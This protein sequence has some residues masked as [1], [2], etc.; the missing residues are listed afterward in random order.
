MFPTTAKVA[1]L[2][3]RPGETCLY[4]LVLDN[5]VWTKFLPDAK[6]PGYSTPWQSLDFNILSSGA[7]VTALCTR[8][9]QV[10]L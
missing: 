6:N 5:K 9:G 4:I 10:S 8:A 2:S 1:T 7:T 3:A